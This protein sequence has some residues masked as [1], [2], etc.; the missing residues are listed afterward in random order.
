MATG[1]RLRYDGVE[2]YL[3]AQLDLGTTT[4]QFTS[5]LERD[6]GTQ[7]DT[8]TGDEYL[9][10]TILDANYQLQEIVHL[11]AYNAGALTGAIERGQEGTS[12]QTH[13][14]DNKVVHAAT[15]EDFMLVQNHDSDSVAHPEILA[16]A[17]A[18]T[19]G[20]LT[21]HE[22]IVNNPHP[23][24]VL[25][26]GDTLDGDYILAAGDPGN[27]FTIE[28]TLSVGPDAELVV[29]GDLVI[30]GRLFLNGVQISASNDRPAAP[31]PN[32]VHIQTYG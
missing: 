6:G 23:E 22:D 7:I 32:H 2:T 8:L 21:D 30:N 19:D 12:D 4:I 3:A 11:T 16:A 29:D 9:A 13:P 24:F 14:V 31:T 17:Q 1:T 5:A 10:L 15:V 18:Y 28:G 25:R 20:A 27:T 26:T